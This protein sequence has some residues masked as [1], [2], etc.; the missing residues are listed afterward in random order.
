MFSRIKNNIK[1][2]VSKIGGAISWVMNSPVGSVITSTI[3]SAP[4]IPATPQFIQYARDN[5]WFDVDSDTEYGLTIGAFLIIFTANMVYFQRWRDLQEKYTA[6]KVENGVL[7]NAQLVEMREHA[8]DTLTNAAIQVLIL[9]I[10]HLLSHTAAAKGDDTGS[11]PKINELLG[12]CR[13]LTNTRK[14]TTEEW[15]NVTLEAK[16]EGPA[17]HAVSPVPRLLDR[18]ATYRTLRFGLFDSQSAENPANRRIETRSLPSDAVYVA[19]SEVPDSA[20]SR[21]SNQ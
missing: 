7:R 4:T 13:Q 1:T 21:L 6:V 14:K 3:L 20:R 18:A 16:E 12:Q 10:T 9:D 17:H 15:V 5:D 8:Q 19:M 11:I 2:G